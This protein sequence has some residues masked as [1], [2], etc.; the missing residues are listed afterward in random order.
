MSTFFLCVLFWALHGSGH[1]LNWLVRRMY[2]T[3]FCD[4]HGPFFVCAVCHNLFVACQPGRELMFHLVEIMGCTFGCY[5]LTP[6]N[7]SVFALPLSPFGLVIVNLIMLFILLETVFV[8]LTR[9]RITRSRIVPGEGI[10]A[11]MSPGGPTI[12]INTSEL[13]V[14]SSR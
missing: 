5:V 12:P 8:L 14:T 6:R 2:F 9:A 1:L 3:L 11:R 13:R 7:V 4:S 10:V